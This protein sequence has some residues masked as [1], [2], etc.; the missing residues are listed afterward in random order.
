M[1][2]SAILSKN[3]IIY[4]VA[5]N[6]CNGLLDMRWPRIYM[7]W[8]HIYMQWV[9]IYMWWL[10]I[11]AMATYACDTKAHRRQ[12][13]VASLGLDIGGRVDGYGLGNLWWHQGIGHT[14]ITSLDCE[15]ANAVIA[16]TTSSAEI[17]P[18]CFGSYTSNTNRKSLF[19]CSVKPSAIFT[20]AFVTEA[21]SVGN[22]LVRHLV[23]WAAEGCGE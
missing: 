18:V 9:H 10:Q 15:K 8:V 19:S 13:L 20:T 6:M 7:R 2:W 1:L 22:S 5:A 12:R 23:D 16:L 21:T 4:S 11:Y 17:S 14:S 3:N